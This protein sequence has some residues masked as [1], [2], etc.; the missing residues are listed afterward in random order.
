MRISQM[1]RI[2]P[3]HKVAVSTHPAATWFF[4]VEVGPGPKLEI[5]ESNLYRPQVI[6][7]C[8]VVRHKAI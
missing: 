7:I 5:Q 2:K 1:K 6:D 8:Q 3:G 4:V